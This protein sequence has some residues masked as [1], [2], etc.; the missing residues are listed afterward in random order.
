M[1][2][3]SYQSSDTSKDSKWPQ[4]LQSDPAQRY[5]NLMC[6][7]HGTHGHRT[8]DCRQLREEVA[9]LF[10]NGHLRE[11]IS[12]RPKTHFRNRDSNKETEQEEPQHIINMIIGGVDIPHGPILKCTKVSFTRENRTRDYMPEGTIFFND[13]DTEGIMQPHNDA[14][15]TRPISS[16]R[17]HRAPGF[18]RPNSARCPGLKRIQD[19]M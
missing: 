6:K 18:T 7:Y 10:N 19:G 3:A 13:E 5:P 17:G 15:V 14:L 9:W 2:P 1:L 11:F 16:D 12:D 4:P 8:K